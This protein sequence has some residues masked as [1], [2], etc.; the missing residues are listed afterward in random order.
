[1]SSKFDVATEM[2]VEIFILGR[3][4]SSWFDLFEKHPR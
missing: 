2:I 3:E 4:G 1:M